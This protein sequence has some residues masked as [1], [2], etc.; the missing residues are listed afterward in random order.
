MILSWNINFLKP[1]LLSDIP[2]SISLRNL[3]MIYLPNINSLSDI[4]CTKKV[5]LL[6]FIVAGARKASVALSS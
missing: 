3:E 4:D 5:F 1:F 2:Q 6:T